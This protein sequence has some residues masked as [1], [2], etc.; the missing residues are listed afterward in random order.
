M[1]K[2]ALCQH[3]LIMWLIYGWLFASHAAH[4]SQYLQQRKKNYFTNVNKNIHDHVIRNWEHTWI[5]SDETDM[6]ILITEMLSFYFSCG[7]QISGGG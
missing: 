6:D 1:Q 5:Y 4:Y 3:G 7:I 2:Q